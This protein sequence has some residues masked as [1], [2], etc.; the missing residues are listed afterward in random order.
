MRFLK[1]LPLFLSAAALGC[2]TSAPDLCGD[3]ST[4][5]AADAPPCGCDNPDTAG[6]VVRSE[7]ARNESPAVQANELTALVEGNTSFALSL[8]GHLGAESGNLFYSPY[9]ISTAL[10]MTWAGARAQ[11]EDDMAAT[12]GFTLPQQQLHNAFNALDLALSSRGQGAKGADGL[13][14][15][16][17][18][19]NA[20]WGQTGYAFE[21]PFL[22]VL[23]QNYGAGMHVVDF[24]R[25]K[26]QAVDLINTWV[27]QETEGKIKDLLS[28]DM[29]SPSTRLVLT[30]TVYFSAAWKDMFEK[31]NT[32]TATFTTDQH[33]AVQV[34]MMHAFLD[35]TYGEGDG[36]KAATLPYDGD[37]LDM[38]VVLPDDL[39]TFEQGLDGARFGEVLGSLQD[40]RVETRIPR[41]SFDSEFSLA[42]ALSKLGMADAFTEKANFSGISST[43]GLQISDVIHKA[44]VGVD[45]KGTEAAAATAVLVLGGGIPDPEE[46]ASITLDR[47][48]LFFIRD[49]ATG[50]VLFVGRVADPTK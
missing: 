2:T 29:V 6:C 39:A 21:A 40:H 31:D 32:E 41:F 27:E 4:P 45:E 46:P 38:V 9:S 5:K 37:Q 22:D 25:K 48:F 20:L 17:H 3:S 1:L 23:A 11:T 36:F 19:S 50:S 42:D 18:A 35:T 49:I 14:F 13:P 28:P 34:P 43:E 12:L 33:Q 7:L 15:R 24:A 47:P 8:Y 30:N 16:L 44:F 10:A 26:D